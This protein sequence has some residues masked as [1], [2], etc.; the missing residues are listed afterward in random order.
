MREAK[1][2][3]SELVG[4]VLAALIDEQI[5][6]FF[7]FPILLLTLVT[8]GKDPARK[9]SQKKQDVSALYAANKLNIKVYY[10][11][12]AEPYTDKIPVLNVELWQLLRNNL[13][14]LFEGR[15][16]EIIVPGTLSEMTKMSPYHK[17]S[18]SMEDVISLAKSHSIPKQDGTQHFQIFFLNGYADNDPGVIGFHISN[19]NIMAL[20]K[21]VIKSTSLA[22][23]PVDLVPKY[24]EQATLIHEMGHAL[25]LVNNGLPMQEK[26]QDK[27]HGAHC[28]NPDCVMYYSNEGKDSMIKFARNASEKLSTVMFDS[29]CL[30]DSRKFKK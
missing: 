19:T 10:E 20:F 5:M 21:D 2:S 12:G 26:H 28:S 15:S 24:V 27:E 14:A 22:V 16:T 13:D 17:A 3:P 18:W 6:K 8:C 29:Q 9:S 1:F 23:G 11:E 30:E 7:L 4:N 25:G